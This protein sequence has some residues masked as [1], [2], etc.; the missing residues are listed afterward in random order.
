MRCREGRPSP[1]PCV[2]LPVCDA[3]SPGSHAGLAGSQLPRASVSLHHRPLLPQEVMAQPGSRPAVCRGRAPG[4]PMSPRGGHQPRRATRNTS[5]IDRGAAI[6]RRGPSRGVP[7]PPPSPP[8]V[9]MAGP[10]RPPDTDSIR[11]DT[12]HHE[13][14]GGA[15]GR[16]QRE[17]EASGCGG[18]GG[19]VGPG[20][21]PAP[22]RERLPGAPRVL[23]G[24]VLSVC[25]GGGCS[26]GPLPQPCS[27]GLDPAAPSAA[28]GGAAVRAERGA[29][30]RVPS[31]PEG[32]KRASAS[33]S[34]GAG[35][36]LS[37]GKTTG[38][39]GRRTRRPCWPCRTA[40]SRPACRCC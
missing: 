14:K 35:W 4:K 31:V 39:G 15:G 7:V 40:R 32:L 10:P 21:S 17:A 18:A 29:H 22:P 33:A 20:P 1:C 34:A 25:Q 11:M 26:A 8:P 13:G 9:P 27:R 28:A 37:F 12:E 16:G 36:G 24:V 30:G 2:P 38:S 19:A 3:P 23:G 6:Q 5:C